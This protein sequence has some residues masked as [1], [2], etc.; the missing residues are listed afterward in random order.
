MQGNEQLTQAALSEMMSAQQAMQQVASHQNIEVPK[1]NF[2]PSRHPDPRKARRQDIKQAYKLL[3]PAQRGKLSPL[4]WFGNRY[5]YNKDTA[6]CV[7][8]GCNVAE[9]IKH[10][11]LY[12][13]ICDED[14]GRSLWEMYWQN[15]VTGE[16]E[17]FIARDKV[18]GGKK[19]RGTYCPEHLHLYHLLTKWEAEE[20]KQN[21]MNPNR[22]RDKVK[23]GV[24]IVTVPISAVKQKDPQPAMLQKYEPFFAELERDAGKT[25]GISIL[26]YKN[27]ATGINDVTMVVFD[28][29][30]FQNEMEQMNMP[31]AEFQ[32]LLTQ[33]QNLIQQPNLDVEGLS[34]QV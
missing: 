7:V 29:R 10:D 28:L 32:A 30:I 4:R 13:R 5:R 26:N 14:T 31:T 12:M 21:E 34:G 22:L 17:A 9:L 11:N 16:P 18:T 25:K 19:M 2:F 23:R 1:V 6:V 27:P 24:S 8:D 20:D 15:P 3:R 33:Q